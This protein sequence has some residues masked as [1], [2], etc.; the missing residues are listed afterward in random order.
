M[1]SPFKL[2][3]N[4]RRNFGC[5]VMSESHRERQREAR[6]CRH[7]SRSRING[8]RSFVNFCRDDMSLLFMLV[9]LFDTTARLLSL[10]LSLSLSLSNIPRPSPYYLLPPPFAQPVS[11]HRFVAVSVVAIM[12]MHSG[13]HFSLHSPINLPVRSS[14]Y[15]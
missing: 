14:R 12:L 11:H 13:S 7:L 15:A 6:V 2:V 3:A 9:C 4:S 5:C 10:P 8:T 1:R